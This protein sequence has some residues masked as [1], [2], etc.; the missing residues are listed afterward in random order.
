MSLSIGWDRRPEDVFVEGYRNY[1]NT[2]VKAIQALC[3]SY[4]AR[5][6]AW[7]KENAVWMDR[8]GN[9]RQ[10]LY[11][12]VDELVNGA[13][14]TLGYGV[15]YSVFLELANQGRFSILLPA[16]DKF[17]AELWEDIQALFR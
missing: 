13:V 6:E 17:A 3:Q 9:A 15:D 7:M 4:A 8:T 5:I 10:S 14:I 2:I 12:A 16:L 11:A 1:W